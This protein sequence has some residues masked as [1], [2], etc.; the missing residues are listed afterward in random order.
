MSNSFLNTVP[1]PVAHIIVPRPR[2]FLCITV[3][4]G[5]SAM[6]YEIQSFVI[7][8]HTFHPLI[9]GLGIVTLIKHMEQ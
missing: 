3:L 7:K 8:L 9:Q 5:L 1:C 6:A 2:K 4:A